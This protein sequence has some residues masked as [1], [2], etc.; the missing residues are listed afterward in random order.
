M[1][2]MAARSHWTA[3]ARGVPRRPAFQLVDHPSDVRHALRVCGA[4]IVHTCRSHGE[5][6]SMAYSISPPAP[7]SVPPPTART[8]HCPLPRAP[9][10]HRH[11]GARTASSRGTRPRTTSDL[12][13]RGYYVRNQDPWL[14]GWEAGAAASTTAAGIRSTSCP[15]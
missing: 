5:S 12:S 8:T 15:S 11:R 3:V 2:T 1:S 6:R 4:S 9:A 13:H 7:P 10:D 14:D